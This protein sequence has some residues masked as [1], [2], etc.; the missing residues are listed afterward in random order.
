MIFVGDSGLVGNRMCQVGQRK[1]LL[2]Q[3]ATIDAARERDW[4]ETDSRNTIDVF[5]SDPNDV[6]DLV[7]VD[8]FYDCRNKNNLQPGTAD[9]LDG[10]H[11]RSEQRL[12][13]CTDINVISH[14]IEL[15]VQRL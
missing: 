13:A 2:L 11:L 7:I 6:S 1:P 5:N 3:L 12:T 9:V 14:A 10:L 4:L 8:A 15:Q